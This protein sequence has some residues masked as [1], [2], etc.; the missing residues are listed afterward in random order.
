MTS[1]KQNMIVLNEQ[2]KNVLPHSIQKDW[3]QD[4]ATK[5]ELTIG[6]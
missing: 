1:V 2:N 6:W 4:F 3:T 5:K